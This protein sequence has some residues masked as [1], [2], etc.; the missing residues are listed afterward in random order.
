MKKQNVSESEVEEFLETIQSSILLKQE[1]ELVN[2]ILDSI[3]AIS[4]EAR[5]I[6]ADPELP[7]ERQVEGIGVRE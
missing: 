4:D 3:Q 7:R 2:G 1:P 5:R 6:L